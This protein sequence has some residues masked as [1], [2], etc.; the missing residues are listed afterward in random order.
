LKKNNIRHE[1]SVPYEHHQNGSVERTN[2]TLLDMARTLLIHAKLPNSLWFLALKQAAFIFNRIVHDGAEK[3]PFEICIGKTPSLDMVKVF[4]CR[5]YL[6]NIKY[7]KQFVPRSS[8]LIHVGISDTSHGW[9]LWNPNS[10]K[11]EVGASVIFHE[12]DLPSQMT[13]SGTLN[14][15]LNSIQAYTLGDFSQIKELEIQ[16]AC[17]SSAVAL[18]PF[19]SD[20]PNTYHQALK[21]DFH[22]EWMAACDA[23][24]DM[25]VQ[26]RVWEEVPFSE[27]LEI[28][29]CRWVFALK[30]S[31]E[32]VIT[33]FKARIVAQGFRQVNGVNVGETFAPTPTFPSLR[34]L[35]AMASKFNWPVA[36]FDVKSAFLHS[37]IDYDVYIR[38]PPGVNVTPGCVLKLR[39]ALYGTKQASRCWWLHLKSRLASIGFQPNLEDQST[40]I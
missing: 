31:Q 28:L 35:L 21:S 6:H 12:D 24:I 17:V 22:V 8:A 27:D 18:S 3:T 40:Y 26:L 15:V 32:G 14:A 13:N 5:A 7:P 1:M 16:D 36:S 10:K 33:R 11:L 4:G 34:M 37:D 19:L 30:R 23:E 29:N 20:A 9:L 25:M 2:R 38:P 39:K